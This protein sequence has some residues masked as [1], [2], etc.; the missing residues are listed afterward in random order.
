[1]AAISM[2]ASY[3]PIMASASEVQE[4][5]QK[6]VFTESGISAE[7]DGSGCQVEGTTLTIEKGGVYQLSGSC[8]NGNVVI[9]K[10]TTGVTLVLDN[11]SLTAETT[12]AICANKSSEVE[13]QVKE[14]TENTLSDTTQENEE[15]AVVK[16]KS[17]ASLTITGG[18]ILNVSGNYQNG[19]NGAE[20]TTV[21]I[22]ETQLNVNAVKNGVA[23][24]DVV[25]VKSGEIS[26][27]AGNDGIHADNVL[28]LGVQNADDTDLDINVNESEE[29]IEAATINIYSGNID[30]TSN[31]DGINAS[32]DTTTDIS[33][34][35][36]GGN[37]FVNAEGDGLDSSY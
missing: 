34:S 2:V 13:I 31:D 9:K 11:L 12:A 32:S 22:E 14:G 17:G 30:L 3:M 33:L 6:F 16:A 1:M 4:S 8:S 19:I 27:T 20:D 7:A 5:S 24:D 28:T 36:Y 25:I 29:G 21:T 26:I 23:S 10:D 18:G 15:K 35:I 37:I